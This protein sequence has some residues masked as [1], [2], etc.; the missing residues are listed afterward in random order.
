M[1]YFNEGNISVH[2]VKMANKIREIWNGKYGN[3]P[4]DFDEPVLL[5]G[6]YVISF[7][8]IECDMEDFLHEII[9]IFDKANTYLQFDICYSGDEHGGFYYKTG[10]TND[11]MQYLDEADVALRD[12]ESKRLIAEC[13]R[14]GIWPDAEL[15]ANR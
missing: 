10:E 6:A 2:D 11:G 13:K 3:N 12:M 14:R 7:F 1:H 9:E 15:E 8:G 5:N 4:F